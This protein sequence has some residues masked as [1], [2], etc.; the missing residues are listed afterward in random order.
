[1]R[2]IHLPITIGIVTGLWICLFVQVLLA[3]K[4]TDSLV[5]PVEIQSLLTKH[6]GECH[7]KDT[8]E[9]DVRFD[10]FTSLDK[11]ARLNLLNK[12]QEQV[13]FKLMPP[14]DAKQP[15]RE[16]RELLANWIQSELRRFNASKLDDKM[17]Y[18]D[19]GNLVNHEK[20]F[21][22]E[23]KDKP[24]T[25][26]RRWLVS[27]QIFNERLISLFKIE[28]GRRNGF[29]N[30]FYGVQNPFL[31]PEFS[32]VRYYDI[33]PLDGG[34]LLTMQ[35]NADWISQKQLHAARVKK[36]EFKKDEFPDK[37]D[38]F[39]PVTPLA[40]ET[41]V[42]KE[43]PPTTEE[44]TAAIHAQFD[45]LLQRQASDEEIT[46]YV[47]LTQS[48]IKLAGN[49]EG[50]RQMLVAVL[51][52]SEFLYRYEFGAGQPDEHGRKLLS[53]R[54]ASYALAYALGDRNPDP[55]L[56]KAA[57]EG[58]LN[59]KEDYR[60]EI[61]RL[62]AD[63]KWF[64]GVIDPAV[65]DNP[66]LREWQSVSH[67]KPVRFFREFFGYPL[68]LKVFKDVRRSNGYYRV[69][70]R[71]STQTPGHLVR[72]ADQLI[73]WYLQRDQ[74][75]FESLLTGDRFFVAD[76]EKANSR[77]DSL[78]TVYERF[79]DRDVKWIM[80]RDK[81][82]KLEL[83]TEELTFIRKHL[84]YNGDYRELNIAMAHTQHFKSKNLTP[85]P[86]W[87]YPFGIHMLTPHAHSYNINP[88]EWD[89]PREQPF[90]VEHRKGIL[91]HPAWLIA[92]A[93][94]FHTDPVRRGK[95]IREKL[96]AGRVPDVP[97]TVQAQVPED[98]HK[99]FR[100]RLEMVTNKSE[101]WKC[102]QHM[103]PL[104]LPF[105]C[106]DDFGRFTTEEPLE[107]PENL[108]KKTTEKYGADTYKT[109]PVVTTGRLE[110]TGDSQLDGDVSDAFELID[111]LAKSTR[112]RQSIIRY[113]FR[114]YMGRNELLSDSQTLID[115]DKAY[116]SSG[117]SF[118][119]VIVSLLTSDSFMYRK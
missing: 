32:G 110:G 47:A 43:T 100:Q 79:K 10:T 75:V 59:S 95:W 115:A 103:N 99:T 86:E 97:I 85:N 4:S 112:V 77:I 60:R 114:F 117:G 21:S 111:R 108:I 1:M 109:L 89:Y 49:T 66:Y 88:P 14:Q 81:M 80:N 84:T 105:E 63:Q 70:D 52:N 6:C 50:L 72:E 51:L 16:E 74:Q 13:F 113:A 23:I 25:P 27:P 119:A 29:I 118:K 101:C 41:I 91:T 116:I 36:G 93:G 69:P 68:A 71:N 67:S 90:K 83:P 45:C 58:R 34:H 48:A 107:S 35:S 3:D 12:A 42:L 38:K 28:E 96:L 78:N 73:H 55:L 26:A 8:S 54:E 98:P 7:G 65:A 82:T 39:V 57:A 31:L 20:L 18:P 64:R 17:P 5:I 102:H 30:G 94:N 40:F 22:G 106:Y 76:M 46:K 61:E 62:M 92:H 19:Y 53:P 56:V 2:S 44:I 9:A 15:S 33:T 11:T 37:R 24:F 87:S 104:G